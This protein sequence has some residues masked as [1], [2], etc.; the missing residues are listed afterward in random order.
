MDQHAADEIEVEWIQL[1]E[2]PDYDIRNIH[3]YLIRRRNDDRIMALS[4][5]GNGYIDV[6]MNGR[7]HFHHRVIAG[8]FLANPDNLPQ[9]DHINHIRSDNRLD[10]IRWVSGSDN[11]FNR[12]RNKGE[13]Y[14]YL[15]AL[16]DGAESITNHNGHPV[17]DGFYH[18]GR[19]Y[20]QQICGKY[21]RLKHYRNNRNGW[22]VKL[23][24]PNNE[25]VRVCWT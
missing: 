3:P 12:Q 9:I 17:A 21:R 18:L 24:G 4:E 2:H 10:N 15:D 23:R 1:R 20:F 13:D 6:C 8:Q 22:L 16:P 7:K 25:F 11:Q 5:H 14:E 19:E